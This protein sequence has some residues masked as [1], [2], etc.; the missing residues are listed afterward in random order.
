MKNRV[1]FQL[2]MMVWSGTKRAEIKSNPLK[3]R[4]DR[5]HPFA[6]F[7]SD[8]AVNHSSWIRQQADFRWCR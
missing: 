2:Q 7:F 5:M 3:K 8:L 1:I 4:G 6:D